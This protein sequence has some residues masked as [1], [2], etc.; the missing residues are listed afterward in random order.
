MS[1]GYRVSVKT[2]FQTIFAISKADRLLGDGWAQGRG[3]SGA[4]GSKPRA[5]MQGRSPL[6]KGGRGLS[7]Q[8]LGFWGWGGGQGPAL[9]SLTGPSLADYGNLSFMLP[10]RFCAWFWNRNYGGI[11]MKITVQCFASAEMTPFAFSLKVSC[12]R[13]LKIH[14]STD[15]EE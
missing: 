10:H 6:P 9:P 15:P 1:T 11:D 14:G 4:G 12:S 3:W 8:E 13:W 2:L 5:G 7:P